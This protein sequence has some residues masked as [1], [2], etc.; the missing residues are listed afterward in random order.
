MSKWSEM[1]ARYD[2]ACSDFAYSLESDDE[3]RKHAH[4]ACQMQ[5]T[6]IEPSFAL[7]YWTVD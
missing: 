5:F 7:T 1:M 6:A 3:V 2:F 4:G